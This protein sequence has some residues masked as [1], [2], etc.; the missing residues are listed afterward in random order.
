M[1]GRLGRR[2]FTLLEVAVAMAILGISLA[3]LFGQI[4]TSLSGV[5]RAR[6]ADVLVSHARTKLAEVKLVR[7]LQPD[8][9][10]NGVFDDGALWRIETSTLAPRGPLDSGQ[11]VKASVSVALEGTNLTFSIYRFQPA[12]AGSPPTLGEQL[13]E[14]R[15]P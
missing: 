8:Q 7:V 12:F 3:A 11:I 4:S 9:Q 2:G 1:I 14:V 15:L 6:R 5:S 13:D 10:V